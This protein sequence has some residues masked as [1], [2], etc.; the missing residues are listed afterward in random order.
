ME[1]GLFTTR[2]C[3]SSYLISSVPFV[4]SISHFSSGIAIETVFRFAHSQL[5]LKFSRPSKYRL[6][7]FSV[8]LLFLQKARIYHA[9]IFEQAYCHIRQVRKIQSVRHKSS[10]KQKQ[11]YQLNNKYYRYAEHKFNVSCFVSD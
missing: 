10:S 2:K 9:E 11:N 7:L 3:S 1:C 4:G 8:V 6:F 5:F